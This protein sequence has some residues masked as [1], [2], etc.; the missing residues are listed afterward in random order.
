[1]SAL[2]PYVIRIV[3]ETF[4]ESAEAELSN[5]DAAHNYAIK[6]TIDIGTEEVLRGEPFF[7]ADTSVE[8]GGEVLKRTRVSI[9]TSSLPLQ[10]NGD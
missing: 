2:P 3:N 1:M 8:Q 10:P 6:A 7:L 5:L 9:T 4:T